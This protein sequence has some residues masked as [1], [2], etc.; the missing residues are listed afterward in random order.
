[1]AHTA[2]LRQAGIVLRLTLFAIFELLFFVSSLVHKIPPIANLQTVTGKR[3]MHHNRQ[4]ENERTQL[5]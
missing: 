4:I 2:V 3:K 5:S 1:M